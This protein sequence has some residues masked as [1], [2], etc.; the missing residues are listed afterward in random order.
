M[1]IKLINPNVLAYMDAVKDCN[2][3]GKFRLS[4]DKQKI[5]VREYKPLEGR[6][7]SDIE[8]LYEN[9]NL[10]TGLLIAMRDELLSEKIDLG[11]GRVK[12][13]SDG[14]RRLAERKLADLTK[15]LRAAGANDDLDAAEVKQILTELKT[16]KDQ[17]VGL[18]D[19]FS[20]WE[21]D[22]D[23]DAREE[24]WQSVVRGHN[25]DVKP[26]VGQKNLLIYGK[27]DAL[28]RAL[29]ISEDEV[30][31]LSFDQFAQASDGTI[32]FRVF[33]DDGA[34]GAAFEPRTV[35][36]TVGGFIEP[37]DGHKAERDELNKLISDR[38]FAFGLENPA[39]SFRA[40]DLN[41]VKA[42]LRL[43]A[44][45]ADVLPN[46]LEMDN[47]HSVFNM[48]PD[49]L[50]LVHDLRRQGKLSLGPISP[51]TW[52]KCL[53]LKGKFPGGQRQMLARAFNAAVREKT[54]DDFLEAKRWND[55]KGMKEW[56]A[57]GFK[58]KKPVTWCPTFVYQLFG[59]FCATTEFTHS[60]KLALLKTKGC[61]LS[62]VNPFFR[63]LGDSASSI[64]GNVSESRYKGVTIRMPK[65]GVI[66][67]AMGREDAW[68]SFAVSDRK[69][70]YTEKTNA[71]RKRGFSDRQI[72]RILPL[73]DANP[74]QVAGLGVI[75]PNS[76]MKIDV[77][78]SGTDMLL[79]IRQP[80][81]RPISGG[82]T[83]DLDA[84]CKYELRADDVVRRFVVHQDGSYEMTGL[85]FEKVRESARILEKTMS[86][87]K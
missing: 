50:R 52:W 32:T 49:A 41:D 8:T 26:T 30:A 45:R 13:L 87:G 40:S 36:L 38:F 19:R 39:A 33:G 24:E 5:G 9:G 22:D 10:R 42:F 80:A 18:S 3:R 14:G 43:F 23:P 53:G 29:D 59:P 85:S 27:T 74:K 51:E 57:S 69:G 17:V 75:S 44:P 12:D 63:P 4:G 66:P 11:D 62:D 64:I 56:L 84:K 76:M 2:E 70:E 77:E 7:V 1:D 73:V 72:G 58:A 25:P 31:R 35:R 20:D 65:D 83:D 28:A 79:A 54:V 48:L 6:V 16:V 68:D 15:P 82:Q 81:F 61:A 55:I 78:K 46:A 71:L 37:A 47:R 21:V 86:A 60:Q 67:A 34:D